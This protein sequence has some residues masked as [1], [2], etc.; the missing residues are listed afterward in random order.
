MA[1]VTPGVTKTANWWLVPTWRKE[2][3]KTN[4]PNEY[5][6]FV[7]NVTHAKPEINPP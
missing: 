3:A 6:S 7:A 2:F 1:L 5:E 4:A